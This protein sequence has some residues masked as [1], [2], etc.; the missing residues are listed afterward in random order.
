MNIIQMWSGGKDSTCAGWKHLEQGDKVHLVCYIPM[1]DKD[2]PLIDKE[3]YNFLNNMRDLFVNMGCKVSFVHGITYWEYCTRILKKGARKGTMQSY[4]CYLKG[5][6]GFNHASKTDACK[7][8]VKT[9]IYDFI[10]IGFCADELD[11]KQL[12]KREISIL[13]ELKITKQQA[14]EFCKKKKFFLLP[15]KQ[16]IEMGV[17]YAQTQKQPKD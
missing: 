3:H 10:D 17:H 7:N 6:C 1:F 14:L 4:P 15:I 12:E 11:R 8:F 16:K 5:K 13:Q 2:I 9:L